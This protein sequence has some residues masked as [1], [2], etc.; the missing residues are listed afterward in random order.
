VRQLADSESGPIFGGARVQVGTRGLLFAWGIRGGQLK[1]P[2]FLLYALALFAGQVL[3]VA[4]T[5]YI[6]GVPD[7]ADLGTSYWLMAKYGPSGLVS[8][9]VFCFVGLRH[10]FRPYTMAFSIYVLS[11]VYGVLTLWLLLGHTY[12]ASSWL[13]GMMISILT[14]LIGTRL[15]I[16]LR[17]E[18]DWKRQLS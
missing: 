15:G 2:R 3:V 7:R 13:I 17:Q 5:T 4:L 8:L 11:E 9:V 10:D 14:L 18:R 12:Y 6:F 16:R 1:I